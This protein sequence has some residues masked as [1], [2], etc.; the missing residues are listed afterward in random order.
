MK[1]YEI[2]EVEITK[3]VTESVTNGSVIS[4]EEVPE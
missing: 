4:G 2:P 1:K 3:I